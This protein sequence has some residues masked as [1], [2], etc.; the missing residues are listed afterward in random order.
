MP[1]WLFVELRVI[2]RAIAHEREP[3]GGRSA[4]GMERTAAERAKV[5]EAVIGFAALGKR[6]V[7]QAVPV[8][9]A[10][11]G[12]DESHK[13][14]PAKRQAKPKP[15]ERARSSSEESDTEEREPAAKRKAVEPVRPTGTPAPHGG[16][17][18]V[19]GAGGGAQVVA[20]QGRGQ[21]ADGEHAGGKGVQS[22]KQ[23]GGRGAGPVQKQEG[24]GRARRDTPEKNAPRERAD[25]G[26]SVAAPKT[27]TK[28]QVAASHEGLADEDWEAR[29]QMEWGTVEFLA[30]MG[31]P[32][33]QE[34]VGEMQAEVERQRKELQETPVKF[35]RND[36]CPPALT[37]KELKVTDLKVKQFLGKMRTLDSEIT[38]VQC[39]SSC[40][41][42]TLQKAPAVTI[43]VK[44]KVPALQGDRGSRQQVMEF[45]YEIPKM[46]QDGTF[47]RGR[48]GKARDRPDRAQM[49]G[50]GEAGGPRWGVTLQAAVDELLKAPPEWNCTTDA[51]SEQWREEMRQ[52]LVLCT[53]YVTAW[54]ECQGKMPSVQEL[55]ALGKGTWEDFLLVPRARRLTVLGRRCD[56]KVA[57][58]WEIEARAYMELINKQ[59]PT[60]M[61][62]SQG[63]KCQLVKPTGAPA[64][65]THVDDARQHIR[66]VTWASPSATNIIDCINKHLRKCGLPTIPV[67]ALEPMGF[68]TGREEEEV[69]FGTM[70]VEWNEQE[71]KTL[72]EVGGRGIQKAMLVVHRAT[73]NAQASSS[74][75]MEEAILLG[76]KD[77]EA[78]CVLRQ[79]FG[80]DVTARDEDWKAFLGKFKSC[81]SES[82]VQACVAWQSVCVFC[83]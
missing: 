71:I 57:Y 48:D 67:G 16:T 43:T 56:S 46:P 4:P 65:S 31:V 35:L 79:V 62:F 54:W 18:K 21:T 10:A 73:I 25:A 77:R 12:K 34:R 60:I 14:P 49:L 72:S 76:E 59:D 23:A 24:G 5:E 55:E 33:A 8:A 78:L 1:T 47:L 19:G 27:R 26:G 20:K 42:R 13:E 17:P 66:Q 28:G 9:P 7:P 52:Q 30:G 6:R 74:T 80:A 29:R 75:L 81:G 2:K 36:D 83:T 64:E 11:A 69:Q 15:E 61:I 63:E 37:F 70:C 51:D 45:N 38:A 44:R 58:M 68:W 53:E 40:S 3:Q 50:G 32:W 22:G 39:V 41:G 82:F